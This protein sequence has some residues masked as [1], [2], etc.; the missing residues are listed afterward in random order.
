MGNIKKFTGWYV[1]SVKKL[2]TDTLYK[3]EIAILK[4]YAFCMANIKE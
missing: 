2:I 1:E 3:R 4:M